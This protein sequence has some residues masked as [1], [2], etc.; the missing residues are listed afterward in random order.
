MW[1]TQEPKQTD[2]IADE[3]LPG[4]QGEKLMNVKIDKDNLEES[5][6]RICDYYCRFPLTWNAMIMGQELSESE[7]CLNC[8]LTVLMKEAKADQ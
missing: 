3:L 4:I 1:R 2:N 5:V 8:P 6:S 7:M